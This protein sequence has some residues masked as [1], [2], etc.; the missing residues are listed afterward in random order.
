MR[1]SSKNTL[2]RD[3][4]ARDLIKKGTR[5]SPC[6]AAAA[7]RLRNQ[8]DV[9]GALP[10][11]VTDVAPA[12]DPELPGIV[13][14]LKFRALRFR[15]QFDISLNLANETLDRAVRSADGK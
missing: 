2:S 11:A 9:A 10:V 3:P 6:R 13:V 15:L 7:A 12:I 4:R 8:R 5:R 14:E 1:I